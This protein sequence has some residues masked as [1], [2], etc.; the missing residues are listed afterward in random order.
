[1]TSCMN[2]LAHFVKQIKILFQQTIYWFCKF[3]LFLFPLFFS[4]PFLFSFFPHLSFISSLLPKILVIRKRPQPSNLAPLA[5]F[6]LLPAARQQPTSRPSPT[7]LTPSI[8]VI[9][10]ISRT[11]HDLLPWP[12]SAR[13]TAPFP[14]PPLPLPYIKPPP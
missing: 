9:F 14:A 13:T 7:H 2:H 6:L 12:T 8:L 3:S 11:E 5:V 1:M 10:L 4:S